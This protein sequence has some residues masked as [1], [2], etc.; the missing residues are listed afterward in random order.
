MNLFDGVGDGAIFGAFIFI[1]NVWMVD[2]AHWFICRDNDDGQFINLQ[3]FVFFGLGGTRHARE[4]VIHAE[5]IL[6]SY[7]CQ[8]LRFAANAHALFSLDSLMKSVRISS[9]RHK[10]SR[11][12]V[13]DNNF[14]VAHDVI[15]VAFHQSLSPQCRRKA[16]RQFD[17]FGRVKILNAQE[18]F[19]LRND[20]IIGRDGFLFFVDFI[21]F[22][23]FKVG[24][25]AS[26]NGIHFG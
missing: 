21:I 3:E 15:A 9:A 26:H 13:D 1:N 10:A 8:R 11:E 2:A 12:F 24:D 17:I 23:L 7:R 16:M 6:E 14:I 4:L 5:I 25:G 18:L 19:N 20:F 22:A